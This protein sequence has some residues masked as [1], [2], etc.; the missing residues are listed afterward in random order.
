MLPVV[1]IHDLTEADAKQRAEDLSI[2][3]PTI[4]IVN[5]PDGKF[6]VRATYPEGTIIPG[7]TS[8]VPDNSAPFEIPGLSQQAA[9][10]E[11]AFFRDS[12]AT[13][14]VVSTGADTFTVRISPPPAP[15]LVEPPPSI[16]APAAPDLDGYVFCLDRIRSERRPGMAFDRTVSRY[17]AYFNRAAIPEISGMAVERQGPG[18][19]GPTGVSQHRCLAAGTYPLF[20]HA[21]GDTNKYRTIGYS[22]PANISVR[23]WPCLGV[24]NTGSRSGILIHCAAGYLMSI[25]CINLT[26]NVADAGTNLLFSDSWARVTALIDNIRSHLGNGFPGQ[27]NTGLPATSLVIRQDF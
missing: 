23:P 27:N 10:A 17:Q 4:E 21:S 12:G 15:A 1:E 13:V 19:N 2:D 18:D 26:S 22:T 9:D 8:S 11:V 3:G 6:T 5:Q 7:A 16:A 24:E 20:T 14:N 25:G